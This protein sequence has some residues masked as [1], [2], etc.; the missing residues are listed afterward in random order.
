VIWGAVALSL[1][2]ALGATL[3]FVATTFSHRIPYWGEA[4]VLFEARRIHD[5]LPLFVDP[6]VGAHEYGEPPSRYY[7]TYPPLWSWVVGQVPL[8]AQRS[9]ARLACSFAWYGSLVAVARG[10]RPDVRVDA[11]LAAV[12][13]GGLWVLAN[14]ATVGRPDAIACAVAAFA[15]DRAM[16]KGRLDVPG[17]LLFVLVPW[18]KPTVLGLPAGA[19][20]G[21][22]LVSAAPTH[23]GSSARR[24]AAV[25]ALVLAGSVA[26]AY[27]ASG[28]AVLDHVVRSN[29][30]PFSFDVWWAQVP[31][32]LPF[33]APL[34]GWAAWRGYRDRSTPGARIGLWALGG[35]VCWT[36][37]ALA[38]TG[39]SSNY[40]MEPCVAALVVVARAAPASARFGYGPLA[41]ALVALLAVL[42]ADVAAVRAAVEHAG[43]ERASAEIVASVR[44][45]CGAA[46]GDVVASDE[47]GIE[48]ALNGRVLTPAYQMSYLVKR[49]SFPGGPWRADLAQARCFVEHT[50]QLAIAPELDREVRE[51][52]V[53]VYDAAGYRIWRHR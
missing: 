17:V 9:V 30:Q 5:G 18:I 50:G 47:A 19:L 38:K 52:F 34:L 4:E 32:R 11:A 45:R 12:F 37:F 43:A 8:A 21:G 36:L 6:L 14:F 27:V 51:T 33:F 13:V 7:V 44:A 15:L 20:V 40:W 41:A 49:G 22:V 53:P 2:V 39:S 16:R 29:A 46:A 3:W 31:G 42:W 1:A 24:P 28:G 10:A 25:V 35:S 23:A 26:V 48:L